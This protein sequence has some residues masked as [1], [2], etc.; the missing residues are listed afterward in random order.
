VGQLLHSWGFGRHHQAARRDQASEHPIRAR[1]HGLTVTETFPTQIGPCQ[2]DGIDQMTAAGV[3]GQSVP[4]ATGVASQQQ[5]DRSGGAKVAV[6]QLDRLDTF[7][8]L[9]A[10]GYSDTTTDDERLQS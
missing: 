7:R 5:P 3:G 10:S 6:S 9:N 4:S 8:S 2:E 1:E